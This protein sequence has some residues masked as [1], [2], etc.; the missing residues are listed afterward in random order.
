[1]QWLRD[2]V[3][4]AHHQIKTKHPKERRGPSG[5]K[6]FWWTQAQCKAFL[7]TCGLTSSLMYA[8]INSA[9]ITRFVEIQRRIRQVSLRSHAHAL[10]WSRKKQY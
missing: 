10:P 5:R 3:L 4:F 2:A 7:R 9:T 1:M 8:I 6:K